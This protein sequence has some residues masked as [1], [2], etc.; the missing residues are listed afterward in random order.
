MSKNLLIV[1]LLILF[2]FLSTLILF[3]NESIRI[4]NAQTTLKTDTEPDGDVDGNDYVV[5]L[6]NYGSNVGN[7]GASKGDFNDDTKVDGLD[8]ITWLSIIWLNEYGPKASTPT[9]TYM[10]PKLLTC[11]DREGPVITISGEQSEQ[12]HTG[13]YP[14]PE[15]VIVDARTATWI[16]VDDY[17]VVLE[18]GPNICFSGGTIW[19]EYP[20]NTDWGTMHSTSGLT[21]RTTGETTVENIRV[22]N[23]GDGITFS[24]GISSYSFHVIGAHM[25]HIRDDCVQNDYMYSA[26]I[27]DSL[28]D[29]CYTAFSA[30]AHSSSGD[31]DGS[32]N[33]WTISNSLIR[34]EPMEK[35]YKDSGLIPGHGPFFKWNKD[36]N[37]S[38]R[39]SLHNNIFRVDQPSNS[40]SGLGLPEGKLVSCSNNIVVWLGDGAY[41]DTLPNTFN[42]QECFSIT[43]DKT[44]WDNAVQDWMNRH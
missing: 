9:P 3:G 4:I 43:T 18:G 28:F 26:L 17:P 15:N 29:G 41:P 40:S 37:K 20:Y 14:L 34:L 21:F 24:R 25:T 38:P 30:Q 31:N 11:F 23:Y 33:V 42:G 22:H 12:Y 19:G 5:W 6:N 7:A 39:L 36:D 13:S 16:H 27:E 8:Y 2:L 35:V 1:V 10:V 32:Q 44:V